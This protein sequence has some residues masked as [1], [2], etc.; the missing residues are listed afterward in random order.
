MLWSQKRLA[1]ALGS[2]NPAA[3]F[4]AAAVVGGA[5][6]V[7]WSV[8]RSII[9]GASPILGSWPVALTDTPAAEASVTTTFDINA[10]LRAAP[11]D[12][13]VQN[14]GVIGCTYVLTDG[15]RCD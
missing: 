15:H 4:V 6:L 9:G 3:L 13:P 7:T 14:A 12:A 8:S 5:L 11:S 1:L 10:A 2:R